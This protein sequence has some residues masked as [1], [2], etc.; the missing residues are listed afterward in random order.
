MY[1]NCNDL[2][3]WLWLWLCARMCVS[4]RLSS[5]NKQRHRQDLLETLSPVSRVM[6]NEPHSVM[7][8]RAAL[9]R[10]HQRL[11]REFG[12]PHLSFSEAAKW[13]SLHPTKSPDT[14]LKVSHLQTALGATRAS[15]AP[16]SGS[17]QSSGPG[18]SLYSQSASTLRGSSMSRQS[19]MAGTSLPAVTPPPARLIR[20]R[21]AANAVEDQVGSTP[22]RDGDG[23]GHGR[24][25]GV[26]LLGNRAAPDTPQGARS[27]A[28]VTRHLLKTLAVTAPAQ[29]RGAPQTTPQRR[30][31][32]NTGHGSDFHS[33]W[34]ANLEQPST[35]S[36]LPPHPLASSVVA[37]RGGKRVKT[38]APREAVGALASLASMPPSLSQSMASAASLHPRDLFLP[39]PG[40]RLTFNRHFAEPHPLPMTRSG[41]RHA[42]RRQQLQRKIEAD[43][44]RILSR[45]R[46]ANPAPRPYDVDEL[47][48]SLRTLQRS[49]PGS[50]HASRGGASVRHSSI[51]TTGEVVG[52]GQVDLSSD[53]DVSVYSRA[54][55]DILFQA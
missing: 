16:N 43:R 33:Q 2:C 22:L 12:P 39:Q 46:W 52:Q 17:R 10:R 25:R 5:F 32:V 14:M 36:Y 8:A 7:V 21:S 34:G 54:S 13:R 1:A 9:A 3:V 42:R 24:G 26:E 50:S 11:C 31:V 27:T 35:A 20:Q 19:T 30:S 53:D 15:T 45:Q 29:R 40:E 55:D 47:T 41:Q 6:Q 4:N 18:A 51:A 28:A 44:A 23:Q 49:Y 37:H 48:S 38:P